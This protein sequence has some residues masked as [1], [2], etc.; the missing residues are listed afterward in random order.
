[1][2]STQPL[3]YD[4]G[5]AHGRQPSPASEDDKVLSD[6]FVEK[7]PTTVPQGYIEEVKGPVGYE[8]ANEEER[9]LDKRINRKLDF[10]VLPIMSINY[11]LA[12]LDKNSLGKSYRAGRTS[13]LI[14]FV[15]RKRPDS[16][17]YC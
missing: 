6:E 13:V 15:C 8:P 12:S 10:I 1:M 5:Y 11:A 16:L 9:S 7:Q 14:L 17:L 2:S 3:D 4:K